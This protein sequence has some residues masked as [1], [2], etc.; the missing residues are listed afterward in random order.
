MEFDMVVMGDAAASTVSVTDLKDHGIKEPDS[1]MPNEFSTVIPD[2]RTHRPCQNQST[3]RS[4][5]VTFFLG[6]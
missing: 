4:T 3:I 2:S 5:V 1:S 6:N